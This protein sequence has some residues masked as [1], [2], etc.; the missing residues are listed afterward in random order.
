[1]PNSHNSTNS[2]S[3]NPIS[4]S[5]MRI[6]ARGRS[7]LS[8]IL[9][10]EAPLTSWLAELD[11]QILSSGGFFD[12]KAIILDLHL[13]ASDTENLETLQNDLKKRGFF[14]IA[15][16]GC[17]KNW[18]ALKQWDM[19]I[20][21]SGGRA[22]DSIEIPQT[23]QIDAETPPTTPQNT[24]MI[25]DRAV[26]SG[27]S[28]Q[29]PDGD[30]VILGAV[31]SGAEIIA[32]GSIHVYGPLRGRAIAGLDGR[33]LA[34]IYAMRLEAELLALDGFYMVAEEIPSDIF[35]KSAQVFLDNEA[36]SLLPLIE[37]KR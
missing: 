32:G 11:K 20:G 12:G 28:I 37:E 7:F 3:K 19:P 27:Q 36:L 31:S 21:P 1:M 34:R 35:G 6:K 25:I 14:I 22:V 9:S 8:L 24:T 4:Q 33:S 17:D 2:S 5:R 29:N 16:E 30:I 23:T 15:V 26:R 13:L 10:P 18:S